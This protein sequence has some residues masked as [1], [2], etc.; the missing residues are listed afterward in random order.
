[1]SK[2]NSILCP[3]A[4]ILI[5]VVVT[6]LPGCSR[7]DGRLAVSGAVTLDG[8]ALETGTIRFQPADINKATG[9]GTMVRDG[10]Y[11]IPAEHGL[12]PGKYAVSVQA[13]EK[14]GRTIPDPQ[15]LKGPVDEYREIRYQEAGKLEVTIDPKATTRFDFSLTRAAGPPP[16]KDAGGRPR[17]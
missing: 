11:S 15:K 5:A 6:K 9:S 3:I 10:K 14:T 4:L 16:P 7:R 1:M 17:K 2:R 12:T 8:K 13:S